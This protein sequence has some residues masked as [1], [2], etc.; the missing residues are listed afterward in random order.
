MFKPVG[1]GNG[2]GGGSGWGSK[3]G[4]ISDDGS[5]YGTVSNKLR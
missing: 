3:I 1:Y 2:D 5:G 4:N